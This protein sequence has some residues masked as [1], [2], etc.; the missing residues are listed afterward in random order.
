MT[1]TATA[2]TAAA[3]ATRRAGIT[4]GCRVGRILVLARRR[5]NHFGG[6]GGEQGCGLGSLIRC[7]DGRALGTLGARR[8]L[9]TRLLRCA[10][11]A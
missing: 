7:L 11:G 9:R 6:T 2:A 5:R 3:A 8:P 4:L 10:L 1:A